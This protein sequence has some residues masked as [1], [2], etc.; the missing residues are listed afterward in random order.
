MSRPEDDIQLTREVTETFSAGTDAAAQGLL[1]L[2]VVYSTDGDLEGATQPLGSTPLRIGRGSTLA[3][4]EPISDGQVS[5]QH[6]EI[7]PMEGAQIHVTDLGSRNG[8]W[9]NGRR[10]ESA[11]VTPEDIVQIGGTFFQLV[12][13]IMHSGGPEPDDAAREEIQGQSLAMR[14]VRTRVRQIA[15]LGPSVLI[16]GESGV[17]KEHTARA[18]HRMSGR[19]GELVSIN[20]AV[21]TDELA[22]SELF[23]H[24]K[25]AFTGAAAQRTGAMRQA[26]GG[27]LFLDEIGEL[28]VS[29]Q[30]KLLRALQERRVR[31]VGSDHELSVDI[32]VVCATNRDLPAMVKEGGFRGD[33][34]SRI[35][36]AVIRVPPLRERR[37]DIISLAQH[38]LG[39]KRRLHPRAVQQLLLHDWPYNV[40][41]LKTVVELIP[42]DNGDKPV[43]LGQA[44]L[45]KLETDRGLVSRPA[46]TPL[47]PTGQVEWPRDERTRIALLEQLLTTARGN[48]AEVGRRLAKEPK[49]IRRWL[50]RYGLDPERF[51]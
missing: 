39:D 14:E 43:P 34:Y 17:G 21:L 9:V 32:R 18:L 1:G 7:R 29:L 10:V 47:V 27:T 8:T 26:D 48:V 30:A 42:Q 31:P 2:W 44:A 45:E 41:D 12:P 19:A 20:C 33:L 37:V 3:S 16:L 13:N 6:L 25:G 4:G 28:P 40:R 36:A 49:S 11:V 38:F 5:S 46:D 23:G 15:P 24:V 22:G 51:R 50:H 35:S